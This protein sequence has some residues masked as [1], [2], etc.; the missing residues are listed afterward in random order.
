MI[1][2]IGQF[3]SDSFLSFP[4]DGSMYGY[5][6]DVLNGWVHLL[7]LI[8]FVFWGIFLIYVLVKFSSSNN[9]KASYKGIKGKF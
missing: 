2:K 9:P 7:M 6:T 3:I 5:K 8:L 4:K 1:D